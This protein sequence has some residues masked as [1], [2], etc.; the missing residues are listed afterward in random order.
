MGTLGRIRSTRCAALP[1]M[2]R[3][4][5]LGQ[6]PRTLHEK[7]TAKSWPHA[8]QR[9]CTKPRE[10]SP[11]ARYPRN[12]LR[13]YRTPPARGRRRRSGA[14]SPVRTA[15]SLAVC[16]GCTVPRGAPCRAHRSH[17]ANRARVRSRGLGARVRCPGT[18]SPCPGTLMRMID[19]KRLQLLELRKEQIA[20]RHQNDPAIAAQIEG[21]RVKLAAYVAPPATK[22]PRGGRLAAGLRCR[23]DRRASAATCVKPS[24][25]VIAGPNGAGKTT[26]MD[27]L[28]VERCAAP[29]GVRRLARGVIRESS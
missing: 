3:P 29:S 2:R 26:V 18:S 15:P 23:V 9:R 24:L 8:P 20:A 12:S 10:K 4:A 22:P 7:A 14:A 25:L 13:T 5:Q 27:R 1:D 16:A 19:E 17:R 6:M 11:H 21:L 28:R